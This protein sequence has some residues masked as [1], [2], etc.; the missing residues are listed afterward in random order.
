MPQTRAQWKSLVQR[1]KS[2]AGLVQRDRGD[3]LR[4][5]SWRCHA[6]QKLRLQSC[7]MS[8]HGAPSCISSSSVHGTAGE[9]SSNWNPPKPFR[10]RAFWWRQSQPSVKMN[11]VCVD[12]TCDNKLHMLPR[13][14]CPQRTCR[15]A[16]PRQHNAI[17]KSPK[18]SNRSHH[19]R[20]Y[21][22]KA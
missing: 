3:V 19:G 4:L 10:Y 2:T 5:Q 14:P 18:I 20:V 11:S 9:T 21:I 16:L 17:Y 7:T 22:H 12:T 13:E 1:S 8:C 6:I 15:R